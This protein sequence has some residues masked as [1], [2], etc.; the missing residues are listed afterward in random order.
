MWAPVPRLWVGN[1]KGAGTAVEALAKIASD[2]VSDVVGGVVDDLLHPLPMAAIRVRSKQPPSTTTHPQATGKLPKQAPVA[3]VE[4]TAGR[5]A[6]VAGRMAGASSGKGVAVGISTKAD[7]RTVR[8]TGVERRAVGTTAAVVGGET[9]ARPHK[10]KRRHV[11]R[12]PKPARTPVA[13]A[14][15]QKWSVVK[16]NRLGRL[17]AMK[18]N[19][20]GRRSL[21]K[22]I[23][24]TSWTILSVRCCEKP[25]RPK[26]GTACAATGAVEN[27]AEVERGKA[28]RMASP[29]TAPVL[30]LGEIGVELCRNGVICPTSCPSSATQQRTVV[31]S[32]QSTLGMR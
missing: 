19:W 16:G 14:A 28:G 1:K 20:L 8:V 6:E 9:A 31:V 25:A 23:R 24:R 3:D 17:M 21:R 32:S 30:T 26:N 22:D 29:P 2:V 5:T 18:G 15:R 11:E 13:M 4:G 27:E 12:G 7:G 10:T